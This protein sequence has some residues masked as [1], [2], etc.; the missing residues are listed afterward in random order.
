MIE[1]TAKTCMLLRN[2]YLSFSVSIVVR[3]TRN[4]L[5]ILRTLCQVALF[6]NFEE[7]LSVGLRLNIEKVGQVFFVRCSFLL[8]TLIATSCSGNS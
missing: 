5:K 7:S 8:T 1:V 3:L 2:M 4:G 6:F